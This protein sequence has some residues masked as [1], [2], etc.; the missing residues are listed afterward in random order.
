MA[1]DFGNA[2]TQRG[3]VSLPD[4][5][6]HYRTCGNPDAPVLVMLHGSPGSCVSLIPLMRELGR[7]RRV[8]AIDTRGNGDSDP[9]P[10]RSPN[11]VDYAR[12]L[13]SAIDA[14][15]LDTFDL[16]GFH[17]GVS[18]ATELSLAAPGR[19]RRMIFEGVSV[20]DPERSGQLIAKDHAPE[21]APDLEGTQLIR[22]FSMVRDSYLFWPWWDRRAGSGRGLGLPSAEILNAE[23]IEILKAGRTYFLSYLAALRYPKRER[24]ILIRHPVLACARP[25]DQ[26]YS[27]LDEAISLIPGAEK[28]VL[29]EVLD[30]RSL[31]DTAR[32][33]IDFL[34]G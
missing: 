17:T 9:L 3:F 30:E 34:N 24:L 20:F 27:Y 10:E 8:I 28:C 13:L 29:P 16:Y 11:I 5:Q 6:A 31:Q 7:A 25:S 18:I 15:G 1:S 21:I 33:M 14:L 23:T 32:A 26:L 19:V 2:I 12:G 22:A 4:G